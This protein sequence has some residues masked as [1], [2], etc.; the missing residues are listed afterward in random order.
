MEVKELLSQTIAWMLKE[1]EAR[2]KGP[3]P[4]TLMSVSFAVEE[5]AKK[6]KI[7]EVVVRETL[8]RFRLM[9]LGLGTKTHEIFTFT[10][11][12][13]LLELAQKML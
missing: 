2:R 3:E 4:F 8:Q 12:K 11:A 1:E 9:T 7:E 10:E 5:A 13:A 6:A